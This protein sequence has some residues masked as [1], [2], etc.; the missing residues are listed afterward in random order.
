MGRD[1]LL[2][3]MMLLTC[4]FRVERYLNSTNCNKVLG[5]NLHPNIGSVAQNLATTS[6]PGAL[7]QRNTARVSFVSQHYSPKRM[8]GGIME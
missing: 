6:H 2:V 7:N 3:A 8:D 5:M 1:Y 4:D